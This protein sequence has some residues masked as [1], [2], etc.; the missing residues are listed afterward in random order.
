MDDGPRTC[1][2]LQVCEALPDGATPQQL[3]E[4][5]LGPI[6]AEIKYRAQEFVDLVRAYRIAIEK[7]PRMRAVVVSASVATWIRSADLEF[8][9][10]V[11]LLEKWYS[12]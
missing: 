10:T 7:E 3:A 8:A 5:L 11:D 9:R 1:A 4:V 12:Q 2:L 6:A